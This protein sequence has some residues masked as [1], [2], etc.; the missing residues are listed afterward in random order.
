VS[1]DI[2]L[3]EIPYKTPGS[4]LDEAVRTKIDFKIHEGAILR[5][6]G[7]LVWGE[8]ADECK[9]KIM[10]IENLFVNWKIL[11]FESEI[12]FQSSQPISLGQKFLTPDHAVFFPNGSQMGRVKS[13]KD[14]WL[15]DFENA[16][17][18]S[19]RRIPDK[20]LICFLDTDEVYKLQNLESE[21]K[22]RLNN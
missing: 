20:T 7:L 3:A 8:T 12:H 19:V 14:L 4:Q 6:H 1:N 18:E 2:R 13:E 10:N 15:E 17:A 9:F 22:R 21:I 16:L 5:N 11:G